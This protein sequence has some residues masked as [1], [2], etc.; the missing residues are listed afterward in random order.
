L[1]GDWLQRA[2]KIANGEKMK[3]TASK[4]VLYSAVGGLVF[5]HTQLNKSLQLQ[6]DGTLQGLLY[7]CLLAITIKRLVH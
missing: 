5:P 3:K 4:I 1:L 2:R 6:H 7:V